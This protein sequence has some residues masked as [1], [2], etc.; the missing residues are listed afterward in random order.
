MNFPKKRF[1]VIHVGSRNHYI[2]PV[3]LAQAGVLKALYTDFANVGFLKLIS[4]LILGLPSFFVP[5]AVRR[6]LSR[7]IPKEVPEDLVRVFPGVSIR[8]FLSQ[9]LF[10]HKLKS[11]SFYYENE[12]GG[13]RLARLLINKNF[14]DCD[15]LYVHPCV[16]T[17]AIIEASRR[18]MFIVYEAISH[19][20]C[21]NIDVEEHL[22]FNMNPPVSEID[23]E[24]NLSLFLKETR[25]AHQI[26]AAS[27]YLA[28]GLQA[29]GLPKEKIFILPYGLPKN[30]FESP[31]SP[32]PGRVLFVGNVN[33]LK[34]I[35]YLAEAARILKSK[36]SSIE[37]R[38]VGPLQ[39][40]INT[41]PTFFGPNYIG[42]VPRGEVKREFLQADL[43]V[44]PTLSD[45]FGMVLI[46]ALHADLPIIAT[47]NCADVVE[48]GINGFIVP[49]RD[50]EM[51]AHKILKIVEN[52][53]LRDLMSIE[54]RKLATKFTQDIYRENLLKIITSKSP[55]F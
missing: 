21:Q 32:I 28:S 38:V 47:S 35:P 48:D 37:V 46:E 54:S 43:F 9:K 53:G 34:G 1:A 25:H 20:Q 50:A 36:N 29:I 44:F 7:N 8:N 42:Q 19:P 55:P 16:S 4:G 15:S 6:L 12:I 40:D 3:V 41:N 33:L 31:P 5:K 24:F 26:L 14:E 2:V 30:F 23:R 52:R 39:L 13:H 22:K 27:R 49:A 51:L 11:A 10:P 45:G 18:N 17:N